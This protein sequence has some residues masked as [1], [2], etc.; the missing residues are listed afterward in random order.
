MIALQEMAFFNN[1]TVGILTQQ[2]E[3]PLQGNVMPFQKVLHWNLLIVQS[4]YKTIHKLSSTSKKLF[5]NLY[6]IINHS[7]PSSAMISLL[8]TSVIWTKYSETD[9]YFCNGSHAIPMQRGLVSPKLS[10]ILDN[11]QCNSNSLLR[12]LRH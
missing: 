1:K 4:E 12:F 7:L 6:L 9:Q 3:E 10:L 2:S 5:F 8:V 11:K